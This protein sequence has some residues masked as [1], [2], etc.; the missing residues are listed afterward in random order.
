V[1][2][3]AAIALGAGTFA[4]LGAPA[5][6]DAAARSARCRGY[7]A[8]RDGPRA[9]WARW[10]RNRR[11]YGRWAARFDAEATKLI[12]TLRPPRR[13]ARELDEGRG[14]PRRHV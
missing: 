9:A 1:R 12:A 7:D 11:N 2:V 4:V 6:E 5:A 14:P 3:R 8:Q 10:E 13:R